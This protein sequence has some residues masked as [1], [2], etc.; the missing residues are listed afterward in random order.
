[1]RRPASL[2]LSCCLGLATVGSWLTPAHAA[3]AATAVD[4]NAI[5]AAADARAAKVGDSSYVA[6]MEV[7]RGGK[8]WK[9]L[10]LEIQV[11]GNGIKQLVHFTGPGDVAGMKVLMVDQDTVFVYSPEFKKVRRIAAHMQNQGFMGSTFTYEDMKHARLAPLFDAKLEGKK[12]SETTLA[13]TPKAGVESSFARIEV[14]IDAKVGGITTVRYYD[15]S[16]TKV[17][18]QQRRAWKKIKGIRVPTE[19]SMEDLKTGDKTIIR[20]RDL[21][22]RLSLPDSAFSRRMLMRG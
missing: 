9:K 17:R 15:A 1:M 19:L 13:L 18:E 21:K 11:K 4:G 6:A 20:L 10:D 22:V 7:H 8:A 16:G 5:L 2:I 14:V 12:G 3:A